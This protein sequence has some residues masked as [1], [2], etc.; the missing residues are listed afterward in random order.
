MKR[1]SRERPRPMPALRWYPDP[2]GPGRLRHGS[3][4]ASR[5]RI[6]P[7]GRCYCL[8]MPFGIGITEMIILLLVLLVVFGPK[9]LP[10]MGRQLG[11][12]MRE[13]KDSVS[14]KDEPEE[15]EDYDDVPTHS[16]RAPVRPTPRRTRPRRASGTPSR[17][18]S[19]RDRRA[20]P[21][22]AEAPE[23]R[24]GGDARRAPHRA[25]PAAD[26]LRAGDRPGVRGRLRRSTRSSS[27]GSSTCFP[28]ITTRS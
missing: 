20:P 24:R 22:P 5:A 19:A 18:H 26:H 10:E 17:K 13:F 6:G 4:R 2:I 8:R 11:K 3:R 28:R 14:G 15:T 23:S 16:R 25:A 27:S 12:G 7:P 21:V 1:G 9:R